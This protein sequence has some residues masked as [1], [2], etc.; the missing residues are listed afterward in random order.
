MNVN[1]FFSSAGRGSG[2]ITS[3]CCIHKKVLEKLGLPPPPK[4]PL[5]PYALFAKDQL[6]KLKEQR[7]ESK[8]SGT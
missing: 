3:Q 7:P 5:N 6:P 8:Q 4:R 2:T 1:D